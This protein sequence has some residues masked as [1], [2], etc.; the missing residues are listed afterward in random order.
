LGYEFGAWVGRRDWVRLGVRELLLLVL[1]QGS[2]T[3]IAG[4]EQG[5]GVVEVE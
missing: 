2:I 5:I 4:M 3:T 1:G